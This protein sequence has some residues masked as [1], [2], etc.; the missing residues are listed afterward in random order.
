MFKN[1]KY[2]N[3]DKKTAHLQTQKGPDEK[4]VALCAHLCRYAMICLYTCCVQTH[5]H[6]HAHIYIYLYLHY[7]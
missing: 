5:T 6:I 7:I 4:I 3:H 1:N 2:A